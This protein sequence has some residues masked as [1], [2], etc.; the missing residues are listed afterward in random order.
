MDRKLSCRL[1]SC[2][3]D[4]EKSMSICYTCTMEKSHIASK[5]GVLREKSVWLGNGFSHWG[6]YC[7]HGV[8]L[9]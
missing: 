5:E 8:Y 3:A 6:L 9:H 4:E 7:Y 2:A 1:V